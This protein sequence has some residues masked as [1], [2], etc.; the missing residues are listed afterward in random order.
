MLTPSS[1]ILNYLHLHV[2]DPCGRVFNEKQQIELEMSVASEKE[3]HNA[4]T[5]TH[6]HIQVLAFHKG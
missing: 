4:K 6:T 2:Y 5:K 3:T 1:W